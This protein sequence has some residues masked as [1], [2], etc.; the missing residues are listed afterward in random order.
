MQSIRSKFFPVMVAYQWVVALAILIVIPL[1]WLLSYQIYSIIGEIIVGMFPRSFLGERSTVIQFQTS[2][3]HY[4][5]VIII[6]AALIWIIMET[7]KER[8]REA[9]PYE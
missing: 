9:F 4:L 2:V 7:L 6:V 3:W 1:V 8:K 5:P